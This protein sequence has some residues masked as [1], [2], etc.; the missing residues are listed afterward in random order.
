[1]KAK[2]FSYFYMQPPPWDY[3]NTCL[4]CIMLNYKPNY[5]ST[6]QIIQFYHLK[7]FSGQKYY[8]FTQ[9]NGVFKVKLL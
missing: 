1:M 7:Q 9:V 3:I 6:R 5:K 8:L 2:P 4:Y